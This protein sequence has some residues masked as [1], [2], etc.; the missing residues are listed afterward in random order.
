MYDNLS[1]KEFIDVVAKALE[2]TPREGKEED[3][4]EG[5]RYITISD[6]LATKISVR[7]KK[8]AERM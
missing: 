3:N 5:V 4:P 6:T 7:L 8:I 2:R 1:D